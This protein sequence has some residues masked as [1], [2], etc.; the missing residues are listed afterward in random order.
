MNRPHQMNID[1]DDL[2]LR[3]IINE[4]LRKEVEFTNKMPFESSICKE[5]IEFCSKT[6]DDPIL[7]N[8]DS[9]KRGLSK[10]FSK[11]NERENKF[12]SKGKKKKYFHQKKKK[13]KKKIFCVKKF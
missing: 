8:L 12:K 4:K 10:L 5:I 3:L 2:S 13:K 7:E 9:P 1:K 11:K 6:K